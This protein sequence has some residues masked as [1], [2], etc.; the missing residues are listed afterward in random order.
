MPALALADAAR[1]QWPGLKVE[2]IGVERGLEARLLPERGE[3][4]LLL[5]M[6]GVKGVDIWQKLRVLLWELPQAVQTIRRSWRDQQPDLLIG[7]GG[8]ASVSG[9]VAALINRVPVILYEQNAMPGLV[10]RQLARLCRSIM[11]GFEAARKYFGSH[12]QSVVTGNIVRQS[13]AEIR[14]QVHTPPCLLVLGGSQGA[15]FLNQTVPEACALLAE[16]GYVFSVRHIGGSDEAALKLVRDCYKRASLEPDVMSFCDDMAAFYASGDLMIARAGAMT[17][18]EAA[19]CGMPS[20][21]VPLP[22]A[23]DDH[24]RHNAES[25]GLANAAC[26]LDQKYMTAETLAVEIEKY[27]FDPERLQQMSQA[28]SVVA[29]NDARQR[30]LNVLSDYLPVSEPL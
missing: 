20:L 25:M 15:R 23:A 21:F 2:F 1:G 27:L 13:I 12:V 4:V 8:Y 19:V 11:L 26:V 24:Q 7:V 22:H 6:H 17:V 10:N 29:P 3:S 9:V 30:Q 14:W 16:K 28:T 5:A 18:S